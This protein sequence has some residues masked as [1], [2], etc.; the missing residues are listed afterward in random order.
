MGSHYPF[1]YLKHKLWPNERLEVKLQFDFQLI[2][3]R[4][5]LEICVCKWCATCRWNALNKDCNFALDLTII[6]DIHK[7]LWLSKMLK[8]PI[9]RISRLPTWEFRDKMIFDYSPHG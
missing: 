5:R 3:V 6:G 2:K 7:T 9:L 4:N 8:V 1:E